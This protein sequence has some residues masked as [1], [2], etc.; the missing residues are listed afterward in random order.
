MSIIVFI[1]YTV[2]TRVS[3]RV[4]N[5]KPTVLAMFNSYNPDCPMNHSVVAY[6][7]RSDY[8]GQTMTSASYFVHTGWHSPS[9]ELGCYDWDWFADDLY[10]SVV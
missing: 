4:Y 2:F 1:P 8:Y 7:Y 5:N 3:N 9:P 6:G 10:L